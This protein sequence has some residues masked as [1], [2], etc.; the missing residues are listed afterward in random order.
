MKNIKS[1]GF[2]IVELLVVIIIIGVLA[3]ISTLSYV[4]I[5]KRTLST[6]TLA[7]ANSVGNI[8]DI[9]NVEN[10]KYP[11]TI[12]EFN[13]GLIKLSGNLFVID[14]ALDAA[15]GTSTFQWQWC[16]ANVFAPAGGKV[17]FW[18]YLAS[19][20]AASGAIPFG[21]TSGSCTTAS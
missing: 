9:Y 18:D 21:D 2:T 7:N 1:R 11:T 10:K 17:I 15:S 20:P 4:G 14:T 8:A 16:G 6:V 5:T 3:A 19:P 12:A 13:A